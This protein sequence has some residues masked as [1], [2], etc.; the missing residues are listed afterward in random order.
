MPLGWGSIN[1]K[2]KSTLI[3]LTKML[4]FAKNMEGFS[5]HWNLKFD[6]EGGEWK[7]LDQITKLKNKP[8]VI[9]CELHFLI[10]SEIK[11]NRFN[12]LSELL[13]FYKIC[14]SKG[15]N[16]SQYFFTPEY[17]IYDIIEITLVRNDLVGALSQSN[18]HSGSN[19][20]KNNKLVIQMP[21]G[22]IIQWNVN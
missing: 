11:D 12:H 1:E 2:K 8:A 17:G 14:F 4:T 3:P 5:D 15:N 22:R 6:I 19:Q 18:D 13:S 10:W 20:V 7:C 21:I 9:V 16:Y